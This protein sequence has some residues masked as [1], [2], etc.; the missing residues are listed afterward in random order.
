MWQHLAVVVACNPMLARLQEPCCRFVQNNFALTCRALG[1]VV[2]TAQHKRNIGHK[3]V[4]L[5]LQT[6]SDE[7]MKTNAQLRKFSK[8]LLANSTRLMQEEVI[9]DVNMCKQV[10]RVLY[11]KVR[12]NRTLRRAKVLC[13]PHPTNHPSSDAPT[14]CRR[15]R[16]RYPRRRRRRRCC[17]PRFSGVNSAQKKKTKM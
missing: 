8:E 14:C 5:I 1:F 16:R 7:N 15:H 3:D 12:S 17:C 10:L 4:A 6:L 11:Y 2:A 9:D 13:T